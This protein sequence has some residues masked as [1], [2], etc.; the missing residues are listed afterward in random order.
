MAGSLLENSSYLLAFMSPLQD[1]S[2]SE[3]GHNVLGPV[4]CENL[5]GVSC[6]SDVGVANISWSPLTSY[7]GNV[8]NS[9]FV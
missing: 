6:G 7:G 3:P 4:Q 1:A 5:F 9:K 2:L 8:E